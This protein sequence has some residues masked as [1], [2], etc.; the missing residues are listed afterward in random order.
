[1]R[2][3]RNSFS[4]KTHAT[5]NGAPQMLASPPTAAMQTNSTEDTKE[6]GP[7]AISA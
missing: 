2:A 7:G 4:T 6:N 3:L 5:P 1:M